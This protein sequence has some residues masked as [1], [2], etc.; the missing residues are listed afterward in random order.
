MKSIPYFIISLLLLSSIA[1]VSV[2]QEAGEYQQTI[3]RNFF[4]P[5]VIEEEQSIRL[6]LEGANSNLLLP[7]KP[8]LP[9][10]TETLTLPFGATIKNIQCQADDIETM[11]LSNDIM[12]GPQRV[13]LDLATLPK[14]DVKEETIYGSEALFPEDW[15]SISAGV[16]LD[17]NM[18]HKTF[19]TITTYPIRYIGA[20]DTINY[21]KSIELTIDYEV[22]NSNP[23]P[24]K[25][26][27]D[28]VIIAPDKFSG[29]LQGL[30]DHKISK[31]M[32]TTLV[33]TDEIYDDYTGYD[34]PERIKKFIHYALETWGTK[35]V[36]LV[37]GLN[38][39]FIAEPRENKNEGTKDWHVPVRYTNIIYNGDEPGYIADLY[40]GD[41]YKYGGDFDNWDY[42]GN[43]I[44]AEN[45]DPLDCHP[46][47][48]VGRLPCR[49]K[50]EVKDIV[51]KIIEYETGICDPSWFEEMLVV[52]GDGFLD[53]EALGFLW[54]TKGLPNGEYVIHARSRNNDGTYGPVDDTPVTLDTTQAT[55]LTFNHDDHLTTGLVYPHDPVA[56]IVSV[57]PGDILGNTDFTYV[58]TGREAYC[59]DFTGW[60]NMRY[61]DGVLLIQGKTYDPRPYGYTTDINVWVTNSGG[62]TVF[63]QWRY[64]SLMYYEGEWTT[65]VELLHGRAGGPY[66]MPPEINTEFVWSSNGNWNGQKDVIDAMSKGQGF[67]FFSGHG[68]PAVW[69]NHYPGIPGNRA[70]GDIYGLKIWNLGLPIFPMRKIKNTY[71]NPILVVGGCHNAMFNVSLIPTFLDKRNEQMMHS[72]GN[73]T[74]ECWAWTIAKYPK[75]GAIAT[76]GN[77][78]YGYGILG[79]WCTTGGV[80]NWITTE[81]F[82]QYGLGVDILGETHAQSIESYI[83]NIGLGDLGDRKTVTQFVLLGDPSLQLGGYA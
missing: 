78:G 39:K 62:T 67:V 38:S 15:Y 45:G 80:D 2:G 34:N 22:P 83:Q 33:T 53:Q 42:N 81:I 21:A 31:G 13:R 50:M 69:A 25:S 10:Y 47:V 28:L 77:T 43:H 32:T 19:V 66:Y 58:P 63:D 71:K 12:P 75:T 1:I 72:Y 36:L 27:Y 57:S 64:D 73:P 8:I 51:G 60:A 40:Y 11:V 14:A 52:S 82:A 65:G 30:V 37:G 23:F 9:V 41:I 20:S 79:E 3:S 76:M 74:P 16:G 59:N 61:V 26:T 49:N 70:N 5:T 54:D 48:A 29:I 6:E 24:L 17:K 55:S 46:D 44:Y 7:G 35:Y 4:E 18:E 56:E 68:S